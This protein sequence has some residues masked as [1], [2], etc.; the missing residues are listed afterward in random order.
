M[1]ALDGA[2][3]PQGDAEIV[4]GFRVFA[5]DQLL[6]RCLG[7]PQLARQQPARRAFRGEL[8]QRRFLA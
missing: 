6:C 8:V 3:T 7:V 2:E 1:G 4:Q 5:A